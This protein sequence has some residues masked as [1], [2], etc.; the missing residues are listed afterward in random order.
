MF[1]LSKI[2][3]RFST[4]TPLR[5]FITLAFLAS[6]V[7]A[8]AGD[9]LL[10]NP[11][12]ELPDIPPLPDDPND[13]DFVNFQ[14][15]TGW[16][17]FG[18]FKTLIPGQVEGTLDTGVFLNAPFDAGGGTIISAIPNA[19]GEQLAFM[20]VDPLSTGPQTTA[21]LQTADATFQPNQ[22]YNFT[23]G[24][25]SS[26]NTPPGVLIGATPLDNPETV[27]LVIGY[28]GT[29]GAD[30]TPL[31]TQTVSAL[32]LS[33]DFTTFQVPLSDFTVATDI[34]ADTSPAIGQPIQVL[35][36]QAGGTSGAFNL[37]NARLANAPLGDLSGDGALTNADI[38]PF[39]LALTDPARFADDFPQTDP[40]TFGDFNKDGELN[41]GDIAGF[42]QALTGAT[43]AVTPEPTSLALFGLGGLL[44]TRRR[45]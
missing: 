18:Q 8:Q 41:N 21:I 26:I 39:V 9:I 6:P 14:E 1:D 35:I 34:L 19:L 13:L 45:R 10:D 42:V 20:V 37:D 44:L 3:K 40:D 5:G 29:N 31:A 11:S 2:F 12:F 28:G 16:Q 25:G 43:P 38:A 36:R 24:V 4:R 17:K 7:A 27:E 33:V 32:D 23:L 30:I 15:I 22:S